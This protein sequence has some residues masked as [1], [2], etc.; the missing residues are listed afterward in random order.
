[1][2]C[3]ICSS[4]D[5][6]AF[7]KFTG[8]KRVT[9]DAKPWPAGGNLAICRHCGTVQKH[10]DK[11]WLKEIAAIYS[12]Y[13][14]YHQSQGEEQAV[15][16]Y[17]GKPSKRSEVLMQFL[18]ETKLLSKQKKSVLDYGCGNGEFLHSFSKLYP[19]D[20]LFGFDL[21]NQYQ[22]QLERI[23]GFKVLYHPQSPPEQKF[24]LVILSHTLEH[25]LD[26]IGTLTTIRGYLKQGGG[27]FIQVPNIKESPFDILIADHLLH[28]SPEN[29]CNILTTAGFTVVRCKTN[30]VA[31]E[32]SLFAVPNTGAANEPLMAIDWQKLRH[33]I[34]QYIAA[35]FQFIA[36][37]ER[38]QSLG[39]FGIFGTSIGATWL[40]GYFADVSFFLDEDPHRIG[41]THF[42]KPIYFPQKVYGKNIPISIP[43]PRAIAEQIIS[44]HFQHLNGF[45]IPKSISEVDTIT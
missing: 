14:I 39:E 16:T 34:D 7:A 37:T 25:L 30:I 13:E 45:I 5:L 41:K 9:S 31:K 40:Y 43:L 1:V 22:P 44:R 11:I 33:V 4:L 6:H 23:P 19:K 42:N 21:S 2:Q 8:L 3:L 35:D 36:D 18:H 12:N 17:D 29:L 32:I 10:A 24:D 15:F 28:F 38:M 26:P 20:D 27:L